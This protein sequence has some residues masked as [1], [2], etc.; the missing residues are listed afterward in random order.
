MSKSIP[1]TRDDLDL[2]YILS[3][4]DPRA[5]KD[6][7]FELPRN[8]FAIL[9]GAY[10][11]V[12]D[13]NVAM[14]GPRTDKVVNTCMRRLRQAHD[15]AEFMVADQVVGIAIERNREGGRART[16]GDM[17][18]LPRS[19]PRARGSAKG[20]DKK[21][22]LRPVIEGLGGIQEQALEWLW[23]PWLARGQFSL[24][25]GRP[26]TGKTTLALDL[27][28]KLSRGKHPFEERGKS[29]L[30][31]Q[32]DSWEYVLRKRLRAAKADEEHIDVL[33]IK[34]DPATPEN[35][36]AINLAA[37]LSMIAE[38]CEGKDYR[39]ILLDPVMAALADTRD[40][41]NPA[42]V[43]K[44]LQPIQELVRSSNAAVL[45]VSHFRKQAAGS[46]GKMAGGA[47]DAV[48]GSQVW[49]AIARTVLA[50]WQEEESEDADN[51]HKVGIIK[52]N[53]GSDRRVVDY[54]IESWKPDPDVA[55]IQWGSELAVDASAILEGTKRSQS[56][57]AE[58]S[59]WIQENCPVGEF[60][61][62]MKIR[63]RAE[64]EGISWRTLSRAKT[65]ACVE[66]VREGDSWGW[67]RT[68]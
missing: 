46:T 1:L 27:A 44:A 43:R 6:P 37:D 47:L 32:E 60:I 68:K 56:A 23:K 19:R 39:F 54:S 17:P 25:A 41:H 49:S 50:A 20:S 30:I 57:A 11:S 16:I 53:L 26:G 62:T 12:L 8:E 14:P 63:K 18:A 5:H 42:Q 66:S 45:G 29:L 4:W 33:R 22:A 51:T 15:G 34:R 31:C 7:N 48:L 64:K 67:K 9:A 65:G 55:I 21:D 61:S 2:A 28:A 3:T 10:K 40:S 52:S 35:E 58:A 13:L 59:K 36:Q 38:A 24:L